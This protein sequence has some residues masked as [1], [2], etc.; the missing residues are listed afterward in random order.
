MNTTIKRYNP[1]THEV[2]TNRLAL[3]EHP[4]S[5]DMTIR[6]I[7]E[8][9]R[10]NVWIG[11]EHEGI[12]RYDRQKDEF[13]QLKHDP[14]DS[15]SLRSNCINTIYEDRNNRLWFGTSDGLSV[16]DD[17]L[18]TFTHYT[19]KNGL[20][21]DDVLSVIEDQ[22]D[23]IWINT[24]KGYITRLSNQEHNIQNFD[25]SN[26]LQP[27]FF[28]RESICLTP[29]GELYFGGLEGMNSI[30]PDQLQN[31]SHAP[32]IVFTD[33]HVNAE[34]INFFP[35]IETQREI[36]LDYQHNYLDFRFVALNYSTP[37]KNQYAYRLLP[38]ESEW[39]NSGNKN[40]VSYSM[41]Q[42]GAYTFEIKGANNDGVWNEQGSSISFTIS[43]PWWMTA[44]FRV[45]VLI[46]LA[47]AILLLHKVR[48]RSIHERSIWLK[49]EVDLRTSHISELNVKLLKHNQDLETALSEIKTLQGI[50]PIC[51]YCKKIRDDE[52]YWDQVETYLSQHSEAKFSHGICPDCAKEH[53]PELTERFLEKE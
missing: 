8:D 20:I 26:G 19:T 38:L 9:S 14:N 44:W 21:D 39:V 40:Q 52:G 32:P 51:S 35:Y 15:H 1:N 48:V 3:S 12:Y 42:P 43:H 23:A 24:M 22:N 50:V 49:N 41:L 37:Q 16:I 30:H 7:F 28:T 46:I 18:K 34:P 5:W 53:Y 13:I 17:D 10:H 2:Q 45:S 25:R 33:M 36:V 47:M 4:P 6:C 27:S 11:T 29:S 31:N